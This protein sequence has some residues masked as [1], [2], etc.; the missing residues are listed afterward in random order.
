MDKTQK[1]TALM[2]AESIIAGFMFTY[3]ALVGQMLVHWAEVPCASLFTTFFAGV[4]IYAIVLTSFRS[5]LLLF[6][7]IDEG[8]P[9]NINYN[10][11]YD[12]FIWAV[13]LSGFY[14]VMNVFSIYL[15]SV[16]PVHMPYNA[17]VTRMEYDEVAAAFLL[18]AI[19]IVFIPT[20]LSRL[21]R[22]LRKLA[23]RILALSTWRHLLT[24]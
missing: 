12:L 11:G 10:A 4:L 6:K 5:L 20:Q 13:I 3:G 15:F 14:V 8:D 19:A 23:A 1:V 16:A 17:P 18:Y 2:T 22:W 9:Y 21:S 7:S 24:S